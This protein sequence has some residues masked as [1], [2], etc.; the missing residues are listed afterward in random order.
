VLADDR[1][2][3]AQVLAALGREPDVDFAA[4]DDPWPLDRRLRA[5]QAEHRQVLAGCPQDRSRQ[6]QQAVNGAHEAALRLRFAE[7]DVERA[8]QALKELPHLGRLTTAGRAARSQ[9]ESCL[10]RATGDLDRRRAEVA[11]AGRRVA[12]L[13]S[14]QRDREAFV[15]REGWRSAQIIAIDDELARHWAPVVLAAARQDDP[16]AFGLDRLR[17]ARVT[18]ASQLGQLLRSLPPDRADA[19]E[20]GQVE[21]ARARSGV[22]EARNAATEATATLT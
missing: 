18:Y 9:A 3:A 2:G 4:A 15:A 11:E 7:G 12:E 14:H 20:R 5:E 19:L 6:L 1:D 8:A 13:N 22:A 21:A 10:T 17:A 16:L